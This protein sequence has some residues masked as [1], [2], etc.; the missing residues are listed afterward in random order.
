MFTDKVSGKRVCGTIEYFRPYVT[1]EARFLQ[2][3]G[4]KIIFRQADGKTNLQ[5]TIYSDLFKTSEFLRQPKTLIWNLVEGGRRRRR[6]DETKC[7]ALR[8]RRRMARGKVPVAASKGG[9]IY[10]DISASL[11]LNNPGSIVGKFLLLRQPNGRI[12]SCA[13]IRKVNPKEA[14]V[15]FFK[16]GVR[17]KMQDIQL[18]TAKKFET[19]LYWE[20][21][22]YISYNKF[23]FQR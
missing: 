19:E 15:S 20:Y 11:P 18:H 17:G 23:D 1:A 7:L 21:Y 13:E 9:A 5:T 8:W 3:V 12:V 14:V 16:Q 22:W 6:I 10:T 2:N 4:G